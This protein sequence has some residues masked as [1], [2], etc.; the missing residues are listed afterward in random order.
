MFGAPERFTTFG[1]STVFSV[2]TA[3]IAACELKLQNRCCWLHDA[4]LHDLHDYCVV[5]IEAQL[6]LASMPTVQYFSRC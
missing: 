1:A 2:T 6:I 5:F 3:S 4:F